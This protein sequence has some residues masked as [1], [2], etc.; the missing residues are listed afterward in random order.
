MFKP[1]DVLTLLLAGAIVL[2]VGGR[3]GSGFGDLSNP[4][5]YASS[6]VESAAENIAGA[7]SGGHLG[8]DTSKYPG[9]DAMQ[10]WRDDG[11]YEWVG[12]YLPSAPCHRDASWSGKRAELSQMGWGLAVVYVGQQTWGKTPGKAE[13]VTKYVKHRVRQVTK[14]NGHSVVRSVTKRVPMKVV[15]QPRAEPGSSCST[16]FVSA[17]RGKSEA[18]DA[19]ARTQAEGFPRGTVIFL[20]VEHMSVVPKA[21]RDYYKEWTARVLAD[22]RYRPGFYAHTANAA[23]LYDDVKGVYDSLNVSGEPPFWV[24]GNTAEFAPGKAPTDVGH[25]FAAVWQGVLDHVE[26]RNGHRLPIDVSVAAT[27]S[28]SAAFTD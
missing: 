21:M 19:I 11:S 10:A 2:G 16:H 13:V 20:D 27:A 23:M 28:P 26:E 4:L 9:D 17:A 1:R 6:E 8:F 22:G 5:A 3:D 7:A 18:D 15:V 12:Y 25:A 24:A 14:R